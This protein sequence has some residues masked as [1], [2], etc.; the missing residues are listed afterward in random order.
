MAGSAQ[1]DLPLKYKFSDEE[2]NAAIAKAL[3]FLD[4]VKCDKDR[5]CERATAV[6][7]AAPP[8]TREQAR[9]AMRTGAVSGPLEWCGSDWSKRAFAKCWMALLPR[10][11]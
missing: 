6:E 11:S 7:R 9:I 1:G 8:I 2:V 5:L 3:N 4:K 10:R